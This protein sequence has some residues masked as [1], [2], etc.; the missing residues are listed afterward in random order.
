MRSKSISRKTKLKIYHTVIKP[1]VIY[2]SETWVIKEKKIIMLN[3]WER[4]I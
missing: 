4:K 1:I 3:V 2:V